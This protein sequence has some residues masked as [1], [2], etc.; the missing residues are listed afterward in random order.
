MRYC[1]CEGAIG[2]RFRA[3]TPWR[4][5]TLSRN[6]DHTEP[7]WQDFDWPRWLHPSDIRTI[8]DVKFETGIDA[9]GIGSTSHQSNKSRSRRGRCETLSRDYWINHVRHAVYML[10]SGVFN[11]ATF[12][13]RFKSSK[14]AFPS[15]KTSYAVPPRNPNDMPHLQRRDHGPNPRLLWCG[16]RCCRRSE[17]HIQL[18]LSSHW[19]SD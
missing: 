12:T 15:R 6:E 2:R 17:V 14:R 8:P 16:L 4:I 7:W 5:E 9:V 18:H 10:R 1:C 13:I 11:T 3:E 19:R